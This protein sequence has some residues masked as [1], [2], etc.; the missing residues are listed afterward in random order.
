ML[1]SHMAVSRR[2]QFL[3]LCL[4]IGQ[5][6]HL[7]NMEDGF[8]KANDTEE[9]GRNHN[10]SLRTSFRCHTLSLLQSVK[11]MEHSYT[12]SGNVNWCNHYGKQYGDSLKN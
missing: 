1:L 7:R 5:L 2:H 4:Y 8:P 12:V 10:V 9:E 3:T 11:K 6:K